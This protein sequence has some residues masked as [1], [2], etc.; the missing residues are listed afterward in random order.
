MVAPTWLLISS[1]IT[2]KPRSLNLSPQY[3]ELAINTGIPFTKPQPAS[4]TCSTYHLVAISEPTGMKLITTSVFVSF[5]IPATSSV[6]PGAFSTT[7]DRYLPTP[8]WVS[9]APQAQLLNPVG[10]ATNSIEQEGPD[11]L[12]EFAVSTLGAKVV[13]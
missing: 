4:S 6:A 11:P 3:S 9:Y 10:V 2:G 1:P 5:K 12:V 13:E 8:S 7:W